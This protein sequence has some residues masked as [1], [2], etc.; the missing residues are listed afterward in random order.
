M[1]TQ[2]PKF[3]THIPQLTPYETIFACA[4]CPK[5]NIAKLDRHQVYS[6]GICERHKNAFLNQYKHT[7]IQTS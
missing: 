3:D 5:K 6:H 7:V 4:W 2:L 1:T